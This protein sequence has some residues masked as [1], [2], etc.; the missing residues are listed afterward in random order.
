MEIIQKKKILFFAQSGVGGAERITVSIAKALNRDSYDI[1]FYLLEAPLG[2]SDLSDFIP[3]YYEIKRIKRNNPLHVTYQFYQ[4][5][6]KEKPNIVFCSAQY[7]NRKLLF[8]SPLFRHCK[9]IVRN[10]NYLYTHTKTQKILMALSYP[11]ADIII[12]QTEEMRNELINGLKLVNKNKVRTIYNPVDTKLI[13][14]KL[15]ENSP[16]PIEKSKVRYIAIGRFV[17]EKGFDILI[18][19]FKKVKEIQKNAELYILGNTL[20]NCASYYNEVKKLINEYNLQDSVFCP[21][22]T[23]NPYKYEKA[24]NCFVLSSRNEG[25]PNVLIEAL[26]IGLPVAAIKC[27]PVIERI[28]E[29]GVTGYLAEKENPISL[30]Q[31]MLKASQLGK[32][33]STYPY[34]KI[35]E[36]TQLFE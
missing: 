2:L 10:A 6:H 14:S 24:C 25:L 19:A 8:L 34:P 3:S 33:S 26:Y 28:V 30:T 11:F 23:D 4:I 13:D 12:T 35:E 9:F 31:A 18:K 21:G 29:E 15:Q 5:L 7:M 36:F 27:I 20:G 16:L 1:V 32:I 22:Y 17:P